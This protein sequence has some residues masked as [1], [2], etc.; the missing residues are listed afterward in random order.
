MQC[1]RLGH[2]ALL[3]LPGTHFSPTAKLA[4]EPLVQVVQVVQV[5][6]ATSFS[7]HKTWQDA[8]TPRTGDP[9]CWQRPKLKTTCFKFLCWW[10]TF[11]EPGFSWFI[12]TSPFCRAVEIVRYGVRGRDQLACGFE[13]QCRP[14][15]RVDACP[16]VG[17]RA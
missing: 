6:T 1:A 15:G 2:T 8:Q 14:A 12:L 13:G 7:C 10:P 4:M 16:L 17:G 3:P 11:F 5:A 9:R